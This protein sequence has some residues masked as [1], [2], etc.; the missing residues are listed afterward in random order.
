MQQM[1]TELHE[2]YREIGSLRER[3]A[4]LEDRI[5]RLRRQGQILLLSRQRK[6]NVL[7]GT[8]NE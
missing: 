7:E 6:I 2:A 1:N 4:D 3:N 8:A 5:E